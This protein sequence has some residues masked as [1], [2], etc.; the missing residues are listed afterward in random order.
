MALII[1][2]M[3]NYFFN[4]GEFP[5]LEKRDGREDDDFLWHQ[6]PTRGLGGIQ[7]HDYKLA[8]ADVEIPNVRVFVEQIGVFVKLLTEATPTQE[9]GKDLDFLL[10]LGELFT[11]VPYGQL[12]LENRKLYAVEDEV[13]DQIFDV[14]VRDFSK[15][16]LQLYSKTSSSERQMELCLEMLRKPVV[17]T[18]RFERVLANH[19]YSLVGAYS[20][21]D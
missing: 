5:E 17:D 18:D 3:S 12:I 2:F 11:L 13:I 10:T 19:V 8:Y 6:G 4:P 16:A 20:M 14:L 9:Q 1:K 21:N 15:Y 7:F